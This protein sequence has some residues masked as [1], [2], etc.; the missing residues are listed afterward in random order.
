[1]ENDRRPRRSREE[2]KKRAVTRSRPKSS[3]NTLV[4]NPF[5]VLL[6]GLLA[7]SCMISFFL[8]FSHPE[9]AWGQQ[10]ED[11][12]DGGVLAGGLKIPPKPKPGDPNPAMEGKHKALV[13]IEKLHQMEHHNIKDNIKFVA[14]KDKNKNRVTSA[15]SGDDGGGDDGGGD[16]SDS[17]QKK[18]NLVTTL[19]DGR[20]SA[21]QPELTPKYQDIKPFDTSLETPHLLPKVPM[22]PIFAEIENSQKLIDDLLHHNKPTI[23][24][25]VAFF[26]N[27]IEKLHVQN[28]EIS[29]KQ[30]RDT[31]GQNIDEMFI[32]ESYYN[33][34]KKEIDP[35]ED[36]Y[37]GRTIFPVR[38]DE[39]VFVSLAAFREHL[40]G[41]SMMSA[42]DKA[43][44]PSKLFIGAV[45]QNCFGLDGTVC[46]TGLE[47]VGKFANGQDKTSVSP[48]P[49][50]ANGIE[51]FCTHEDYKKYCDSGQVRVIYVHDT[52]ALGPQT[53]RFYASK[54]WGGETYFMQMDAHLEFAPEWE[55]YYIDEARAAKNYPKSVLSS[56]PPGFKEYDGAFKGGSRGERLCRAHFSPSQVEY[57]ILR[58]EQF[59]LTPMDAK[60]PTQIPFMA[61]GFFF[62]HSNLL[63]DVPFDP[64]APWC[65][66]GEEIALS[67]RAWTNGWDIYAPRKNVIA[68]Q[69]RPGRLGLPKFWE[70]VGRDSGR[71]SLNTRLQHHVIRRI[72]HMLAYP[73]DSTEKVNNDGDSVALYNFEHYSMGSERRL[74]DYLQWTRI[75]P[76]KQTTGS[77]E[78]CINADLP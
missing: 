62:A 10:Q 61:A 72:K 28:K 22:L 59:G 21:F 19:D 37:R 71:G 45:V 9:G 18:K 5:F 58:I 24:G 1:M 8:V 43:K 12:G 77:M 57:Q 50:D 70:S 6:F 49:P 36:A 46:H 69:Y 68:H 74:E 29:K 7:I 51:E 56:Y 44:D 39:S 20:F 14:N 55:Q 13:G 67:L 30:H 41:K 73:T 23:A 54:L 47:V 42:F 65:F 3:I 27:Y 31:T 60:Y 2:R 40:L 78:W 75:N 25:I 11:G 26:N 48:K 52:D 53:A 33:L 38:E 35:L 64:Y 15:G 16:D 4:F 66:M 63:Q 34:T 76:T 32:I 17:G